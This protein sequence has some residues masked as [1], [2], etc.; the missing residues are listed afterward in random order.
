MPAASRTANATDLAP[1]N[2]TDGYTDAASLGNGLRVVRRAGPA[3][4]RGLLSNAQCTEV[5]AKPEVVSERRVALR[6]ARNAFLKDQ[7]R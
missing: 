1:H 4:T 6:R 5:G 7:R 3:V 2:K